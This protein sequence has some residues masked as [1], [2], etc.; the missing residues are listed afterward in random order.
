MQ[1]RRVIGAAVAILRVKLCW[2]SDVRSCRLQKTHA[3]SPSTDTGVKRAR[4]ELALTKEAVRPAQ[5]DLAED[6]PA[7]SSTDR[8][9]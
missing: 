6:L 9:A 1:L 4:F 5:R 2:A 7:G 8:S 3:E